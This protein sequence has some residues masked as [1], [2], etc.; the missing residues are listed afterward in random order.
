[1]E[2]ALG[3]LLGAVV[4]MTLYAALRFVVS[5]RTVLSEESSAMQAALHAASATLPHLRLG[6]TAQSAQK[7]APHLRALTQAMLL[8]IADRDTLLAVEGPR[9]TPFK[10]GDSIEVLFEPEPDDRVHVERRV[11][12]G[13]HGN[14]AAVVAPLVVRGNRIGSLVALYAS[15]RRIRPEHT[16]TVQ[17]AASLVGAQVELA[18]I[19]EQEERLARAE[20]GALRAQ[21]SPHFV[22]NALSA[23]AS[24]IHSRPDEARELLTEFAEF[25]R[26]A[27]ARDRSNVTLADE[28]HY[29]EKYLRLERARFAERLEVR[30]EVSPEI[31]PV[32]V[33]VLSLQPLVEN[34][35]R[36]G[37]E[38]GRGGRVEIV[39]IDLG[40]DARVRV[41]D[42]GVGMQQEQARAALAGLNGGIGVSNVHRRLQSTFGPDY[43]LQIESSPGEGTV[44]EL[45][46]PKSHPGARAA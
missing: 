14:A 25:I 45:T 3:I 8:A 37:V 38:A 33:P 46:V 22:Y 40:A 42:D 20:L 30:L 24:Y 11:E 6:L 10:A 15:E 35:I 21:I 12:L 44:V 18:S 9:G 7:A 29:V 2:I 17:E 34:S 43:G 31:L 5:P 36:H 28:L 41:V 13:E 32:M 23:V 39:G 4:A 16:R 27:F 26:Y 1:M 19:D